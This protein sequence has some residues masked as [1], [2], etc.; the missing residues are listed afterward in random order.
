[1]FQDTG[2]DL[3]Y[4]SSIYKMVNRLDNSKKMSFILFKKK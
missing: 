4:V 2:E 1:M 3:Q